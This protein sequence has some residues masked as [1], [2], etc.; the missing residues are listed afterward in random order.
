MEMTEYVEKIKKTGIEIPEDFRI[1][2]MQRGSLE[3]LRPD[4]LTVF[5]SLSD[6]VEIN[7]IRLFC[8]SQIKVIQV[9]GMYRG[10]QISD[11]YKKRYSNGLTLNCTK[12][13]IDFLNG[14]Q[15]G[16]FDVIQGLL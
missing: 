11:N 13:F 5:I 2:D 4:G 9:V 12:G 6:H 3:V 14:I 7:K 8:K 15:K 10:M 16:R 1:V